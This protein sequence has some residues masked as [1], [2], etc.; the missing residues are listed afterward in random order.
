MVGSG[1]RTRMGRRSTRRKEEE[2]Q[3]DNDAQQQVE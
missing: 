1:I 2:L 3:Q